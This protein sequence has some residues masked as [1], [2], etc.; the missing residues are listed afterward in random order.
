MVL[1]GMFTALVTT[2]SGDS[3]TPSPVLNPP[4]LPIIVSHIC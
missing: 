3:D 1:E 2:S 4:G